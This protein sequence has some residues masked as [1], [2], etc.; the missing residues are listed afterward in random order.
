VVVADMSTC[1]L[2]PAPQSCTVVW[3]DTGTLIQHPPCSPPPQIPPAGSVGEGPGWPPFRCCS[4]PDR[5]SGAGTG[6]QAGGCGRWRIAPAH[7]NW[8]AGCDYRFLQ[9]GQAARDNSAAVG[10]WCD[11]AQAECRCAPK[12]LGFRTLDPSCSAAVAHNVIPELCT[13]AQ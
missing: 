4:C 12:H 13:C 11:T 8:A 6:Q 7:S 9:T 2:H 10:G 5:P 3:L 1:N